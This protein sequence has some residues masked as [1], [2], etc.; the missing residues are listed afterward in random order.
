MFMRITHLGQRLCVLEELSRCKFI[1]IIIRWCSLLLEGWDGILISHS[2]FFKISV[3]KTYTDS[4]KSD[5]SERCVCV[6]MCVRGLKGRRERH[7]I[8][9]DTQHPHTPCSPRCHSKY[10]LN[11]LCLPPPLSFQAAHI[12]PIV[13]L[14]QAA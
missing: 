12:I 3:P 10:R 11:T 5:S 2:L 13:T 4:T 7:A 14:S 1:I 8:D 9:L 6:C